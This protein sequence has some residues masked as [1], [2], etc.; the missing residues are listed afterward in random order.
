M[1]VIN[2]FEVIESGDWEKLIYYI[3][4]FENI[5]PYDVDLVKLCDK[6]LEYINRAKEL[7]FRIPAKVLY[8]A[9]FLLKL[10]VDLLFPKEQEVQEEI[11]EILELPKIDLSNLEISLPAKRLPISQI[12]LE[13]LIESLRRVLTLKEKKEKRKLLRKEIEERM[14]NYFEEI[15]MEEIVNSVY[16]KISEL[17]K[18]KNKVVFDELI[19]RKDFKDFYFKFVSILHLELQ[20]KIKTYQKDHF[21][22]IFIEKSN[23]NL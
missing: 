2:I 3:V 1:S 12:T 5:N 6:F 20:R 4:E 15:N 7:D 8:I 16:F 23:S 9:V 19:E 14:K 10:K 22:K 17:L 11:R 18:E 13:E 21:E